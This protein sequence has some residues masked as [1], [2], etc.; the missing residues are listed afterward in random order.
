MKLTQNQQLVLRFLATETF[1]TP[2]IIGQL[3]KYKSV[4]GAYQILKR[5]EGMRL[6]TKALVPLAMGR[7][8][9]LY[10]INSNGLASSGAENFLERPTFQKSKVS[11]STLQHK[12]DIQVIHI[13][14]LHSGWKN[15]QDGS[16]LGS[17]LKGQKVPDAVAV[18]CS[19]S[20]VAFEIEREIKSLRRYRDIV[21]SHLRARKSGEW[22]KIVYLCPNLQLSNSLKRKVFSIKSVSFQNRSIELTSAHFACFEFYSYEEFLNIS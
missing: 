6:L 17:R 10:G 1:S 4:Q 7:S 12:L 19:G 14:A 2:A 21:L 22:T 5:M 13:F 18:D 9:T 15:W 8:I 20:K 16:E 3:L 11:I